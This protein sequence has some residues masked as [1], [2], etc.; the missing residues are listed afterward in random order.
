MNSR[1]YLYYGIGTVYYDRCSIQSFFVV[2]FWQACQR[3]KQLPAS[4]LHSEAKKI[5]EEYVSPKA[6]EAVNINQQI[7]AGVQE[8]MKKPTR[9]LFEHAEVRRDETVCS[10]GKRLQLR[11][12]QNHIYHLMETDSYKRFLKS[13]ELKQLLELHSSPANHPKK[14]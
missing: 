8:A 4:S 14:G 3:F 7:L 6:N 11:F 12:F 13:P 10:R 2:R 5:Y 1:M 9:Y